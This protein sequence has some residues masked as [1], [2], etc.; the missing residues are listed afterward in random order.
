MLEAGVAGPFWSSAAV[1]PPAALPWI[2][3]AVA[4][5]GRVNGLWCRFCTNGSKIRPNLSR[6]MPIPVS[7]TRRYTRLPPVSSA[8]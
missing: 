6:G 5:I 4:A 2:V 8:I 7:E 1:A 3:P